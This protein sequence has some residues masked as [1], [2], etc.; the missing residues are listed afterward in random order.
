MQAIDSMQTTQTFSLFGRLVTP[1]GQVQDACPSTA[2]QAQANTTTLVA[3]MAISAA[4]QA[5]A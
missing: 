1:A 5:C 2:S 4:L 3:V